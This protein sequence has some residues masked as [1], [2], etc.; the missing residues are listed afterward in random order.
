[1]IKIIDIDSEL[2]CINYGP[3]DNGHIMLGLKNGGFLIFDYP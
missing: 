2:S 3:F 1:M